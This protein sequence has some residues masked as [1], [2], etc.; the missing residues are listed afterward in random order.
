MPMLNSLPEQQPLFSIVIATRNRPELLANCLEHLAAIDFPREKF[1]VIVVDDGSDLPLDQV[2]GRFH[3]RIDVQ[4][5]RVPKNGVAAAR[6]RGV[7]ISRGDF[8]AFTDDDVAVDP[9][10]L[11]GLEARL[12]NDRNAMVGGKVI[13]ALTSN[14]YSTTAQLIVDA[15]YAYYN[16]NGRARFFACNNLAFARERFLEL[17]GLVE[18][19]PLAAS[20]DRVFCR[21]WRGRHWSL[22][23]APDAVAR[24]FHELNLFS[25]LEMYF[26]Y[27]RG[28]CLYHHQSDG[29]EDEDTVVPKWEFYR[30]C[31]R[32]AFRGRLLTD[33]IEITLLM[34][35]WQCANFA[36]YVFE[37]FRLTKMFG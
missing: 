31:L 5:L 19:W 14:I 30:E 3:G 36:G 32:G 20:E 18:P 34:V 4:Y 6:N 9:G 29:S 7:A 33:A 22:I 17:G 12:T 26:R 16:R 27:G 21:K 8:I 1:E 25:F 13:N 37:R 2:C 11:S 35:L 15:V 23:F 10:W 28:A 24:H